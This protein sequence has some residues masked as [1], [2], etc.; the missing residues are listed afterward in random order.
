M[1]LPKGV[2][3]MK[4]VYARR[5]AWTFFGLWLVLLLLAQVFQ[6]KVL[7]MLAIGAQLVMCVVELAWNRCPHC[8]TYVGRSG[9]A[10]CP[11]CGESLEE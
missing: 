9:G 8:R 1:I 4:R 7:L 6:E 2:F 3:R 11:K 5:V 10:Y